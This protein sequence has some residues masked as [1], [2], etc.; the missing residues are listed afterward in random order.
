MLNKEFQEI[1]KN[2]ELMMDEAL[3]NSA[4]PYRTFSLSSLEGKSPNLRT[5]VLREFSFENCFIDCHSDIRSPKINELRKND[6]FS[7]LFYSS[8]EKI[9]LRFKGRVEIFHK[10]NVT[11]ERWKSVT[12]SSKRC[13][14]GPYSPSEQLEKYHP[15]IPENVKFKNPSEDDSNV[16]YDNF[17]IIR[18]HFNE[19]DYLKLK[20]S[21]HLRCKLVFEKKNINAFWLAP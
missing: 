3:K 19:L 17:V 10:N 15:N 16:G 13:Y 1:Y 4:H 14:L 9:Q 7:A 21:G 2:I 11:K 8:E 12:P 18:C 6:K 5:V 20:Y